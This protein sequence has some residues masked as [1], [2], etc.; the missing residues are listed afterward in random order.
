MRQT[1]TETELAQVLRTGPFHL[2]LRTALSVRGLP[3]QRVRH[4]LEHRG[5]KLGVTSL[6]YWQQGVRRPRRAESL[7]AVRA[8]EEVLALPEDSLLRLLRDGDAAGEGDRPAGRTYRSL[9]E[10]SGSVERL[11]AAMESPVD[12]GLHTVGHQERVRIGARRELA[13]RSSRHVVRAHRDGVD[14]YLAV[15]RGDPGCDPS[16]IVVRALENCRTGRVRWD[17][18]SG[19]LVAELLFDTRLRSGETYLFGYGF[20]DGTG[21]SSGEYVRGFTF[22]GGQYVL[23]VGFD[24]AALPVRCRRFAQASAGAVRGARGDLTLTGRHR[25][26]HLVEEGVRPGLI[27]ID[28]DW[29]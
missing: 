24:E 28:W 23:Q 4:H 6:S 15:Y 13:G 17:G 16:R 11:L 18:E 7:R 5:V 10:A 12:G 8:L 1:E 19:V 21:G 20:E 27:G 3:L 22:G 26:V 29:E 2:A 14:R 25:T 9:M